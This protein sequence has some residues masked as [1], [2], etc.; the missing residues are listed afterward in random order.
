MKLKNEIKKKELTCL[1][2]TSS[3]SVFFIDVYTDNTKIDYKAVD[4]GCVFYAARL[5]YKKKLKETI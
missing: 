4:V 2:P 3:T 5:N 1:A